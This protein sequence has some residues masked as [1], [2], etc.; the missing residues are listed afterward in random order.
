MAN[1]TFNGLDTLRT[2]GTVAGTDVVVLSQADTEGGANDIAKK[3]T[4]GDLATAVGTELGLGTAA[5]T[6]STDYATATQGT[7]AD[8]ALQPGDDNTALTNAANFITAGQA[9]VQDVTAGTG[10][11]VTETNGVY[12]VS[13][14]GSSANAV[15]SEEIPGATPPVLDGTISQVVQL[16]Q[17]QYES[18]TPQSDIIYV[19]TGGDV[20]V[21]AA[22]NQGDN[23]VVN[24]IVT[25][26]QDDYDTLVAGA[27]PDANTLYVIEDGVTKDS[28]NGQIDTVAASK[29]YYLDADVVSAR[30]VT[31][32][33][34]FYTSGASGAGTVTLNV[35]ADS[36]NVYTFV[37]SQT[38]QPLGGPVSL[39][40]AENDQISLTMSGAVADV[41]DFLFV[42][43]YEV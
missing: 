24:R 5:T 21:T 42:L 10:V 28:Y 36:T 34:M 37:A 13:A 26:S 6:A 8:S 18:I 30:T 12:E 1:K 22:A 17:A 14:P 35:G 11:T 19:I 23:N 39:A 41:T 31:G 3:T 20:T 7:L 32:I 25:I 15:T 40:A 9:P 33:Q 29:T 4:V 38:A 27:G 43:E 16:T 2:D